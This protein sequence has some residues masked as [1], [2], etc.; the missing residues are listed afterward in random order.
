MKNPSLWYIGRFKFLPVNDLFQGNQFQFAGHVFYSILLQSI[1]LYLTN[2]HIADYIRDLFI[3]L[4]L[5]P[6]LCSHEEVIFKKKSIFKYIYYLC[7]C[8]KS[9][10]CLK[11][12]TQGAHLLKLQ[13]RVV[14][15]VG[16]LYRRERLWRG[17]VGTL[18]LERWHVDADWQT[19]AQPFPDN[20]SE[21][22]FITSAGSLLRFS[23]SYVDSYV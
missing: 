7:N 18:G 9:N 15:N 10:A 20:P 2:T 17:R 13:G 22:G 19:F 5:Q 6:Q 8:L 12:G 23:R 16:I 21:E 1:F 14:V 3:K 11:F 4:W